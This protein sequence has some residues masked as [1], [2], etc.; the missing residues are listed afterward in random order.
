MRIIPFWNDKKKKILAWESFLMQCVHSQIY[1]IG[2]WVTF[3]FGDYLRQ[4]SENVKGGDIFEKID[5]HNE[6]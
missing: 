5:I 6:H 4:F 2:I 1:G 3:A